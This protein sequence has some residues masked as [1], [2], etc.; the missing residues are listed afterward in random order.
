MPHDAAIDNEHHT[1]GRVIAVHASVVDV[2]FAG[3]RLSAIDEAI[4]ITGAG[5]APLMA[6]VRLHLDANTVHAVTMANPAGLAR[7]APARATGAPIRVQVDRKRARL[8]SSH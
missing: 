2:R 1:A 7:G 6:E 4:A 8:N 5:D 3:S